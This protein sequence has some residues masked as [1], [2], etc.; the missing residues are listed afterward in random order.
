MFGHS[1]KIIGVRLESD[2][3]TAIWIWMEKHS[4]QFFASKNQVFYE[5][6]IMKL[7]EGWQK[8]IEQ[9]GQ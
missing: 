9:N 6:G 3:S 7:T 5:S 2:P 8:V 4:I 1:Q